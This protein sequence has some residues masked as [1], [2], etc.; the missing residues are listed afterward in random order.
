MTEVKNWDLS[1]EIIKKLILENI[2]INIFCAFSTYLDEDKI[3]IKEYEE[4]YI[5]LLGKDKVEIYINLDKNEMI[6]FY[7]KLDIFILTSS[8][9]SFG[10][11]AI[12]AMACYC[13]VLGTNIVGLKEVIGSKKYLYEL[14]N[15]NNCIKIIKNLSKNRKQLEYEKQ[16]FYNRY[17]KYFSLEK[18]VK[19]YEKLYKTIY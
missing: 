14:D 7:S 10:R 2:D 19:E 4:K 8:F 6:D 3:K 1:I 15:I 5:S 18:V 17:K 13:C 16:Y 9:E 11:T 12:E